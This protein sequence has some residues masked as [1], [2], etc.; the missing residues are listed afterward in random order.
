MDSW[1]GLRWG[2]AAAAA[3]WRRFKVATRAAPQA[4][5]SDSLGVAV[6]AVTRMDPRYLA[7]A[8][9]QSA[10]ARSFTAERADARAMW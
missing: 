6:A 4:V 3:A 1:G 7:H 10:S 8:P 5:P 9:A 2:G